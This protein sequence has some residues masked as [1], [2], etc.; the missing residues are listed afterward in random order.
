MSRVNTARPRGLASV[1]AVND[2]AA[3]IR[4]VQLPGSP[5]SERANRDQRL[6]RA[7]VVDRRRRSSSNGR[8]APQLSDCQDTS[9]VPRYANA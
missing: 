5:S 7:T 3:A 8:A 2:S 9:V 6:W 1:N 4:Q